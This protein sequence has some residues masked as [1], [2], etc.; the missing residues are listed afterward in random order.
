MSRWLATWVRR[1][2]YATVTMNDCR[3]DKLPV[4]LEEYPES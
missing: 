1:V 4:L 2:R 3:I